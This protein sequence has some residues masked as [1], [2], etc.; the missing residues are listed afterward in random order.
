[1]VQD[2]VRIPLRAIS[3]WPEQCYTFNDFGSK[4]VT[5]ACWTED[6]EEGLQ[7]VQSG[8]ASDPKLAASQTLADPD[9]YKAVIFFAKAAEG[10]QIN[11][12]MQVRSSETVLS[13]VMKADTD[14][15]SAM[16]SKLD[17]V[18]DV[19]W[20]AALD[21]GYTHYF[22]YDNNGFDGDTFANPEYL[23]RYFKVV[24]TSNPV[25]A[26]GGTKTVAQ[27]QNGNRTPGSKEFTFLLL[28]E[29]GE[30]VKKAKAT[31]TGFNSV[32]FDFDA[33]EYTEIYT[34]KEEMAE[35]AYWTYVPRSTPSRSLWR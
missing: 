9:D 6:S 5:L 31:V 20:G 18:T 33:I 14:T 13:S 19:I 32:T 11:P 3:S 8:T 25:Y 29:Q 22:L 4:N 27:D 7:S 12:Q 23:N 26:I 1:M 16:T 35:A 34:V 2:F 15:I 24:A 21:A 28:D 17:F 30:T 10:Y